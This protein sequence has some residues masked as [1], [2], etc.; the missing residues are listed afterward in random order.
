MRL[1]AID[2]AADDLVV[3]AEADL[4]ILAAPVR[5]N[6]A[7]LGRARRERQAAGGRHRHRQHQAGDRRGRPGIAGT[8]H[9]RWRPS[10]RRRRRRAG[11]SMRAPDSSRAAVAVHADRR[12]RRRGDREA[13]RVCRA[14][15]ARVPATVS[16]DEHDRLLAFLSHLPQLTASA[17][18][19]VVGE[20]VG[21]TGWPLPAAASWTRPGSRRVRRI[22]GRT[23]PP[24]TPTRSVRRWTP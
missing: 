2:V 1:H 23:S 5:Q 18:M 3:L 16:V 13:V 8:V 22:S 4:V 19:N 21:G 7:L 9:L 14:R 20:A 11:S 10:A 17:L 24:P 6:I 12:R 15:S